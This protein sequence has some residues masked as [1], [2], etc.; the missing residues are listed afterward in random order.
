MKNKVK[1]I[2]AMSL[3]LCLT[4]CGS[5]TT[6]STP[7]QE[8]A[9]PVEI[10]ETTTATEVM[11]AETTAETEPEL[12]T[13]PDFD[14]KILSC[15]IDYDYK[16]QA[17]LLVEYEF[18]NHTD[19]AAAFFMNVDDTAYQNGIECEAVFMADSVDSS[20]SQN[21][22]KPEVPYKFKE[23]YVLADLETPVEIECLPL[24]SFGNVK[25]W[26]NVTVDLSTMEITEKDYKNVEKS[27]VDYEVE[28]LSTLLEQNSENEPYLVV[29]YR[30]THYKQESTSFGMSVDHKVYQNGIECG[31][32]IATDKYDIGQK[33]LDIKAN[34]PYEFEVAYPL[35]NDIDEV[36]IECYKLMDW[37]DNP[38][39]LAIQTV[40]LQ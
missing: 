23:G 26:V 28:I 36:T 39:P 40:K 31:G 13:D 33:N 5:P 6:A 3:C 2:I 8:S 30:F 17:F 7:T 34:T 4:A 37:S 27:D 38:E 19:K 12:T 24:I 20:A 29:K 9:K 11:I 32:Y 25:P 16:D 35:Q 14:V 10:S 18:I 1:S 15:S 22:I 21:D